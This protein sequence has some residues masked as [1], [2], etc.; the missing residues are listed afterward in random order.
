MTPP[1]REQSQ[2]PASPRESQ[3]RDEDEARRYLV[4]LFSRFSE[5]AAA[6]H[7]FE[8]IVQLYVKPV[9]FCYAL[10][11]VLGPGQRRREH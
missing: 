2:L 4:D 9:L 10:T 1:C 7:L 3:S 8:S 5:P 11:A 6:L